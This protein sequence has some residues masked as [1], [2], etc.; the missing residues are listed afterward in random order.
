MSLSPE[1]KSQI[2]IKKTFKLIEK[3]AKLK[4]IAIR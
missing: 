1:T 3:T 2:I 4:V